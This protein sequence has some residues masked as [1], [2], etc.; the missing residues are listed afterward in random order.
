[1]KLGR[2][3]ATRSMTGRVTSD[4]GEERPRR[5]HAGGRR[6]HARTY[7]TKS[8]SAF[9]GRILTTLRAGL[10]LKSIG[11]LVKGLMPLRA[12]VAAFLMT[13]ILARPGRVKLPRR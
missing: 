3:P 11:S 9:S 7:L 2:A 13:D 4:G 12:L 8:L 1:M 10:A 5:R 6:V